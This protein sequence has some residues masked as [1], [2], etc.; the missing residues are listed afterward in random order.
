[1]TRFDPCRKGVCFHGFE[2]WKP[3]RARPATSDS[4]G[5]KVALVLIFAT[6]V[7]G[8]RV[9]QNSHGPSIEFTK[10]PVAHEGGP[11]R[12]DTIEGRVVGA[13][14]GQQIVLYARSG[15]WWVQPLGN[16]P[17]TKIGPDSKWSN[18]T[19][20]GTEYAALLVE[21][22]YR[23]PATTDSLPLKGGA[24]LAV[25]SVKG[26]PG[27]P[28]APKTV[29]FSGYEWKVR[30]VASD[31]GGMIT[32]YDPANVWTT[33]DGA[34]HLRISNDSRK[35]TCAEA[36][37]TRSLGYGTY[38]FVVRDSSHLEPA[39]VLSMFTWD[40]L[41]ADQNHRELDVEIS[42]WGDPLRKNARYVVQPYYVPENVARFSA[43]SGRLTHSFVWEPGKVSFRTLLGAG[44]NNQAPVVA[45]HVFSSGVPAP[46]GETVHLILYD[47]ADSL[48]PLRSPAE[49]VIEKFEFLP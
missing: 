18:T 15:T 44:A 8:C 25:A 46:G 7:S 14:S 48:Q 16:H 41:G 9:R 20:F 38:R 6:L 4:F 34:L 24:V 47:F 21:P 5:R 27:S 28:E 37:L 3:T 19:H 39:T 10:V 1:M 31:R 11:D 43:P 40:D 17:F 33:E 12:L 32:S 13:R 42:R 36:K 30:D 23:P 35:W 26:E 22:G 45:E 29:Q 49:V 2:R